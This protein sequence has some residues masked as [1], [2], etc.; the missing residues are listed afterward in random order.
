VYLY[1]HRND[2][3]QTSAQAVRKVVTI[4]RELGREIATPKEAREIMGINLG[5]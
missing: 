2:K 5:S 1:P 3:I 4:A